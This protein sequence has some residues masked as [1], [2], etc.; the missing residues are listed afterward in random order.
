MSYNSARYNTRKI[1]KMKSYQRWTTDILDWIG[2][3]LALATSTSEEETKRICLHRWWCQ[4]FFSYRIKVDTM[5]MMM[6][7]TSGNL[8]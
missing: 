5:M 2:I 1:T 3:K 6:M 4:L 8:T 7:H